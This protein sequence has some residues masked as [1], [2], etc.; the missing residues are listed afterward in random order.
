MGITFTSIFHAIN[1]YFIA[2][3][4]VV[5]VVVV[6]F[7]VSGWWHKRREWERGVDE[8]HKKTTEAIQGLT[9]AVGGLADNVSRMFSVVEDI[10]LS[11]EDVVEGKSPKT[12]TVKG[13]SVLI[14][15]GCKEYIDANMGTLLI[16][17]SGISKGVDVHEKAKEIAAET[18]CDEKKMA[19]LSIAN[20]AFNAGVSVSAVKGVFAIYL[21]DR[22]LEKKEKR[23]TA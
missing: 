18:F 14:D 11:T 17:F 4:A 10:V 5:A 21:R 15:T 13:E 12:L 23:S 22:V 20:K 9:H 2:L 16:S 1:E 7:K 3:A 8:S 6:V 19:D